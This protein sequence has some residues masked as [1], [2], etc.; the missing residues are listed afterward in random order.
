MPTESYQLP[1][2]NRPSWVEYPHSYC[3]VVSQMLVDLRPWHIMDSTE[4]A[5]RF[6]GLSKRYPT[7]DLLPFAYRQD[8]DDLACWAKGEGERVFIVHDYAS[9]GWESE[10]EFHDVWAWFRAAVEETIAWE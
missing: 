8:N 2:K 10:G 5:R 4:I 6:E 9:P 3:R 1:L 7:R